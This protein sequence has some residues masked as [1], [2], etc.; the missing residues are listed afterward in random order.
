MQLFT[1]LQCY[2]RRKNRRRYPAQVPLL[3]LLLHLAKYLIFLI[4]Q[5]VLLV[6]CLPLFI[7]IFHPKTLLLFLSDNAAGVASSDNIVFARSGSIT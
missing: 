3:L 4:Y 5:N 7:P 2:N 6:N 1:L